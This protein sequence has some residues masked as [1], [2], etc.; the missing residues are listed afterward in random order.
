MLKNKRCWIL[1]WKYLYR[2]GPCSEN[3]WLL[4]TG[5]AKFV[6]NRKQY[7]W[8]KPGLFFIYFRLFKHTLQFLQQINVKKCPSS[9][10]F[11]DSNSQ[12]L[13]HESP[14]ITTRP[15][16]LSSNPNVPP[17][18]FWI[19]NGR[20][21]NLLVVFLNMGQTRPLFVYFH[22]FLYSMT[23]KYKNLTICLGFE[24]WPQNGRRRRIHWAL[25]TFKFPC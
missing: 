19:W 22:P 7:T 8:A 23:T 20:F 17:H 11:Q 3:V 24:P 25:A 15:G 5:G 14:P 13:E 18:I 21:L 10:W 16:G 9:I 12:P 2:F 6:T 4:S 1:R